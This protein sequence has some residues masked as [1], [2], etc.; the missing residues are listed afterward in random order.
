[1]RLRSSP[2][3][4]IAREDTPKA[5]VKYAFTI[6]ADDRDVKATCD[7]PIPGPIQVRVRDDQNEILL[8]SSLY[9]IKIRCTSGELHPFA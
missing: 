1:M 3:Q 9:N 2:P 7:V 4:A 8:I 5:R 6:R